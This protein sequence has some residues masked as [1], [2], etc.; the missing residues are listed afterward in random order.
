MKKIFAIFALVAPLIAFSQPGDWTD[1][2]YSRK[3]G[4]GGKLQPTGL[5]IGGEGTFIG[6]RQDLPT[7]TDGTFQV[8]MFIGRGSFSALFLAG[9]YGHSE[10]T[11]NVIMGTAYDP[12]C[13]CYPEQQVI[14]DFNRYFNAG[15]FQGGIAYQSKGSAFYLT[16]GLASLNRR[17]PTVVDTLGN[18]EMVSL[19][20]VTAPA[21]SFSGKFRVGR[22]MFTADLLAFPKRDALGDVFGK[23]SLSYL[24]GFD[25]NDDTQLY[26]GVQAGYIAHAVTGQE[27]LFGPKFLLGSSDIPLDVNLSFGGS[28]NPNPDEG[29]GFYIT[30]GMMVNRQNKF[31]Y[32]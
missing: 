6:G 31:L 11:K 10:I 32:R 24:L 7:V 28:Y 17:V 26:G 1:P 12:N 29:L 20:R 13:G 9:V 2:K 8:G 30:F 4:K 23:A 19:P 27:F 21:I 14:R 18:V 15:F 16:V 22:D 3:G 5:M 25:L